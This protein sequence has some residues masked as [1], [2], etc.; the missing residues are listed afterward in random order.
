MQNAKSDEPSH[1]FFNGFSIYKTLIE[2]IRGIITYRKPGIIIL[3][4]SENGSHLLTCS[5]ITHPFD[6]TSFEIRCIKIFQNCQKAK[7]AKIN[8]NSDR[9]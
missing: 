4:T 8:L 2:T 9:F 7:L 6:L 1:S 5:N 3:L